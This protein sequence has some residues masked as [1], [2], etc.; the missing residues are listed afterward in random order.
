MKKKGGQP[1]LLVYFTCRQIP[2]VTRLQKNN[3]WLAQNVTHKKLNGV[4]F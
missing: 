4:H 2:T 1:Y 3:S